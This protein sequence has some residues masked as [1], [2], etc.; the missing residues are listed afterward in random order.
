M[1]I[2]SPLVVWFAGATALASVALAIAITADPSR[3][4]PAA[5]ALGLMAVALGLG[6]LERWLSLLLL[7]GALVLEYGF[8]NVGLQVRGMP[9]PLAELLIVALVGMH[10]IG[11]RSRPPSAV[12]VP[13]MLYTGFVAFR[14]AVDYPEWGITAVRDSTT[15]IESF[16]LIAGYGA[17]ARDGLQHWIRSMKWIF[18]LLLAYASLSPWKEQLASIGPVVGLQRDVPLLG[19][20]EGNVAVVAAG[21]FFAIYTRGITRALLLTWVVGLVGLFQARALYLVLPIGVILLGWALRRHVTLPLRVAAA[22]LLAVMALAF[23]SASG[24]SGRLGTLSPSFYVAH[25]Q[26]LLGEEG[27]GSGTVHH[28][29]AW[30]E[31][32][33]DEWFA[34][35]PTTVLGV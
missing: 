5:L 30:T 10:L 27:P 9:I 25:V 22:G 21:L 26:T 17:V 3:T 13:L 8:A 14:L 6:A 32:A 28:R 24:V 34:S 4:V 19:F 33:L 15:A 2:P 35:R 16:V 7:G 20:M 31:L 23:V 11:G 12:L 29:L 18:V 1:R